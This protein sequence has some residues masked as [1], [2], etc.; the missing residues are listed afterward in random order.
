MK[1][2]LLA[3]AFPLLLGA[4]GPCMGSKA[5]VQPVSE[6]EPTSEEEG[7]IHQGVGPECPLTWHI[8]T[9]DGRMLWPVD[10]PAFQQE[11]LRVRFTVRERT[12]MLSICMA[13]TIVDVISIRK[14]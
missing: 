1:R 13:G 9:S 7:T 11:G 14:I 8:A 5:G 12:D 2:L 6:V 4:T 3:A 10:D